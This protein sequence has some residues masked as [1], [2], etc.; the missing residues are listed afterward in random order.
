[1]SDER[2]QP[3]RHH[4]VPEFYLKRFTDA[5]G[6]VEVAERDELSRTFKANTRHALVQKDFY[7]LPG[8]SGEKDTD[9]EEF[10]GDVVERTGA[11][12]LRRI[13]DAGMF[14]PPPG[15]REL[16]SMF[17]S[18]QFIR[19][20][21]TRSTL[22]A[23]YEATAKAVARL[24]TPEMAR[25]HLRESR[26]P[27]EPPEPTD[28]EVADFIAFAH[29]TDGYRVT[30]D[31]PAALHLGGVIELGEELV[32]YFARRE[33]KVLEFANDA[34]ITGDEPIVLFGNT[35]IAGREALGVGVARRI[36]FPIDPRRAL[37]MDR[38]RKGV[39]PQEGV[40]KGNDED[41]TIINNNLAYGCHRY[42]AYR[43][44][45]DPMRGITVAKKSAAVWTRGGLVGM[46][47]RPPRATSKR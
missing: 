2:T 16:L 1:M 15:L 40:I 37:L 19:G 44:G 10:F 8:D 29:D 41:A 6:R 47:A 28:E 30:V 34:I 42:I 26:E 23:D 24:L 17:F 38:P 25:E 9:V 31:S 22:L 13:F 18:F 33:W 35:P 21:A 27:D 36:V 11:R 32:P 39:T 43:P 3:R 5:E 4:L 12:S 46:H 14:P 20:E 7:T 45:T